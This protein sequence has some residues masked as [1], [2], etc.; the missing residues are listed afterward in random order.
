MKM[1]AEIRI[2]VEFPTEYIKYIIDNFD[3]EDELNNSLDK[4][5]CYGA[6]FEV[7]FES[8]QYFE[9]TNYLNIHPKNWIQFH[10]L[11]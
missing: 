3:V 8:Q 5:I 10:I 4:E 6:R 9:I 1:M 2:W 7:E 11:L